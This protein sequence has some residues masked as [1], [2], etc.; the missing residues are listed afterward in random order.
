[1]HA[2]QPPAGALSILNI[3]KYINLI[4]KSMRK[5]YALLL[6]LSIV[7]VSCSKGKLAIT[8]EEN[9]SGKSLI[10]NG[11]QDQWDLLGYGYDL[12]GPLLD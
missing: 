6:P 4:T 9:K 1:M 10:V 7:M 5:I 2:F 8:P 11:G 12:T 3:Y